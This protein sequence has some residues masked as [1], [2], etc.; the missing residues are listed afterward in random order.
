MYRIQHCLFCILGILMIGTNCEGRDWRG[1]VPLHS[2]K[3]EVV[4][5]LGSPADSNDIRSIYHLE[6]ED[7]YVVFSNNQHCSFDT[8]KIPIGTV[9][10]VQVTPRTKLEFTDL[11]ID[12]KRLR[13]FKPSAQDSEWKGFID[14]EEGLIVR[15]YKQRIDR[16]FYIGRANDR[17]RCPS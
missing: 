3:N 7:V 10:L 9:L 11:R 12:Q 14:E 8:T 5:L 4:R 17:A 16:I 1:I 6:N 15:S 13:E 2:T